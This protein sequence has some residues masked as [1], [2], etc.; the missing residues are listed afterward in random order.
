MIH[1]APVS[2]LSHLAL[3]HL[4][5]VLVEDTRNEGD[6]FEH[7]IF[8]TKQWFKIFNVFCKCIPA[9]HDFLSIEA[10]AVLLPLFSIRDRDL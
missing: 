9:P 2:L 10:L 6:W 8:A 3:F 7:S 1:A 5:I 4:M